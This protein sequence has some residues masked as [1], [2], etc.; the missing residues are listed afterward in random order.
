MVPLSQGIWVAVSRPLPPMS[1]V[2]YAVEVADSRSLKH[3]YTQ[4]PPRTFPCDQYPISPPFC[5]PRITDILEGTRAQESD[6]LGFRPS[7]NHFLAVS[8][9]YGTLPL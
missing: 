8:P 3:P 5:A 1:K 7:T 4:A 2:G 6:F 9:W